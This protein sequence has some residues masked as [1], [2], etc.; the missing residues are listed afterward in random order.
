MPLALSVVLMVLV[1][2]AAVGVV[3][4]LVDKSV[5]RHDREEDKA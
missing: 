3:G 5:E 4:Y 2:V 1:V